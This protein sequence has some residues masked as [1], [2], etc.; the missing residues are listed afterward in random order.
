MKGW[1]MGTNAQ[2]PKCRLTVK[3]ILPNPNARYVR[4]ALAQFLSYRQSSRSNLLI[5]F[6]V[7]E[8]FFLFQNKHNSEH[9]FLFGSD[10]LPGK[11]RQTV[12]IPHADFPISSKFRCKQAGGFEVNQFDGILLVFPYLVADK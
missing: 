10:P 3:D 5:R 9:L 12:P 2:I 1:M 8:I 7:A 6:S 11:A 4:E